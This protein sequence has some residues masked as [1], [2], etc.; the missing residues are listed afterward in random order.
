M[1]RE[2]IVLAM[3]T[4][5]VQLVNYRTRRYLERCLTTV[6]DDLECSGLDYQLG[7]LDNASGERI[8]DFSARFPN[9]RTFVAQRNLGFGGG[10]NFLASE[11]D[12]PYIWIL[13]PDVELVS[14]NTATRLLD[15][16][17]NDERAKAVGPKLLNAD[18]TA[19]PY[20]H[21]RLR[22]LRAQI[23]LRGGH[24]YWRGTDKRQPVAWASGAAL[25]IER[26]AFVA[27]GG[28]DEHLF[29][30]KEEEDLCL[31]L[32]AAGGVV[33]YEPGVIVRHHGGVVADR[34]RDLAEA[35]RYFIDKH[36]RHRRVQGLLARVH[37]AL[38]YVRL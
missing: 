38:A 10:H 17:K 28:F 31:R 12:A 37:K 32:R 23:A 24:A 13:N 8:D 26:A 18:G 3:P 1:G 22:G 7:V 20:D 36:C 9:C 29:L 35:E 27:L 2:A 14:P 11:T 6:V 25:L 33:I 19:Q 5:S 34:S 21:G 16:L 15:A 30:Y 4:L